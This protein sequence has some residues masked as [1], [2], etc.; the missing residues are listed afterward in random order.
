MLKE[1]SRIQLLRERVAAAE[2]SKTRSTYTV[3]F[4]RGMDLV[5]I[6]V[7]ADFPLYRIQSGRTRRAQA[8]Y[9]AK[10]KL[11]KDFWADPEDERVQKAQHEILTEMIQERDLAQDLSERGQQ[12]AIILTYDGYVVNGN[13]RTAALRNAEVEYL[14]AVVLP[15]DAEKEEIYDLEVELQMA[16]DTKSPYDWVNELLT[17]KYGLEELNLSEAHLAKRMRLGEPEQVRERY[18]R[19]SVLDQYL[20]W[21]GKPGQYQEIPDEVKQ[22]FI[23]LSDRLGDRNK[24]AK[25]LTEPAKN[26]IREACFAAIRRKEGY[27]NVRD[28]IKQ[29]STKPD[30][31]L[32]RLGEDDEAKKLVSQAAK[33]SAPEPPKKNDDPLEALATEELK[34]TPSSFHVLGNIFGKPSTATAAAPAVVRV[35]VEMDDEEREAGKQQQPLKLVQKAES[36]LSKVELG[37]STKDLDR[38]AKAL[39]EVNEQVERLSREIGKLKKDRR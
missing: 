2:K 28:I 12:E 37:P 35:A 25:K 24:S 30:E 31:F 3:P 16:R 9:L 17:I 6:E 10:H 19:L 21:L 8:A 36:L 29:M 13:R 4:R 22:A 33:H 14:K 23:D 34:N 18:E 11:P 5:V 7:K 38:I 39:G 15:E 27:E 20:A 32:K 26:A 1:K